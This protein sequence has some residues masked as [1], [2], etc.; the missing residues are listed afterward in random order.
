[1]VTVINL[2]QRLQIVNGLSPASAGIHILPLLM[3]TAVGAFFTGAITSKINI[4]WYLLVSSNILTILGTGLMSSLSTSQDIPGIEY[5]YQVIL[6]FG[7][8]IGLASLM[9]VSRCEVSLEDNGRW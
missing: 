7:F 8:G 2:P 4:S 5:F 3:M 6:G 9:V 1:M